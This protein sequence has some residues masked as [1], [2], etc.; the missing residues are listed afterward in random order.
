MEKEKDNLPNKETACLFYNVNIERN[1]V[2]LSS[3]ITIRTDEIKKIKSEISNEIE[4]FFLS[5]NDMKKNVKYYKLFWNKYLSPKVNKTK[6]KPKKIK[7]SSLNSK[8]YFGTF[9]NQSSYF[10]EIKDIKYDKIKKTLSRSSN[11]W[12]TKDPKSVKF[13]KLPCHLFLRR[14]DSLKIKEIIS[15]RNI[16]TENNIR[17]RINPFN[18]NSN[19]YSNNLFTNVNSEDEQDEELKKEINQKISKIK[20]NKYIYFKENNLGNKR[21]NNDSSS[22]LLKKFSTQNSSSNSIITPI[23]KNESTEYIIPKNIKTEEK[24]NFSPNISKNKNL[25]IKNKSY[26]NLS[27]IRNT[28]YS[29]LEKKNKSYSNLLTYNQNFFLNRKK[30]IFSNI[31][32]N[33][34]KI[35][36]YRSPKKD[37]KDLSVLSN[38]KSQKRIK[39]IKKLIKSISEYKNDPKEIVQLLKDSKN[40]GKKRKSRNQFYYNMKNRLRLLSIVDNLKSMKGNAPDNLIKHLNK[41]YYD[42]SKKMIFNDPLTKR[43]N[44]IYKSSNQGRKLNEKITK[45]SNFINRFLSKNQR[46]EVNLKNRIEKFNMIVEEIAQEKDETKNYKM[47]NWINM[48]KNIKKYTKLYK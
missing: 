11:F 26:S 10:D 43:I 2:P 18:D 37:I 17:L 47:I 6:K 40:D 41:D 42:K 32:E 30:E 46:D 25:D 13:K 27:N 31:M 7:S 33:L 9:F 14:E 38:I 34:N 28:D 1:Q 15:V 21:N 16:S 22:I 44:Q 35:M 5:S 29:N 39:K 3:E 23:I 45:Q 8:I 19:S 36:K 20:N 48:N 24:D 12:F 4:Q